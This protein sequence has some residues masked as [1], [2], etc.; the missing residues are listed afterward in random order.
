MLVGCRV[1][2]NWIQEPWLWWS[3]QFNQVW[4]EV[5]KK[6]IMS[7]IWF[8]WLYSEGEGGNRRLQVD[9]SR[10]W[11]WGNGNDDDGPNESRTKVENKF[12]NQ[13]TY[14]N[15]SHWYRQVTSHIGHLKRP[16]IQVI[17][18][19]IEWYVEL[20]WMICWIG[21]ELI[22]KNSWFGQILL[23]HGDRLEEERDGRTNAHEPEQGI[24]LLISITCINLDN[25][26]GGVDKRAQDRWLWDTFW[27]HWQVVDNPLFSLQ[28]LCFQHQGG[29]GEDQGGDR[30]Y[31][32]WEGEE[33]ILSHI[34]LISF[35]WSFGWS[36]GGCKE[37]HQKRHW[38]TPQP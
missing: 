26:V 24:S 20:D 38:A 29:G 27:D 31:E 11:G 22:G 13:S 36:L 5:T 16:S 19:W 4:K 6:N 33:I 1:L 14:F 7:K 21:F 15:L 17:Y 12:T 2:S 37:T 25:G 18:N 8:F 35:I 32:G 30:C 28:G 9:Q 3:I 23:F 10:W 34:L